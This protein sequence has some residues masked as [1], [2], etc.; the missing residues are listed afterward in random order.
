[1]IAGIL[2]WVGLGIG[3]AIWMFRGASGSITISGKPVYT[4]GDIFRVIAILLMGPMA[5]LMALFVA[6]GY[7]VIYV[8]ELSEKPIFKQDEEIFKWQKNAFY[9][10]KN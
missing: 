8:A 2:I 1:M 3:P 10:K 6:F 7:L 9:V 5:F 4:W